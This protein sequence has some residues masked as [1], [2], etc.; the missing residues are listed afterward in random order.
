MAADLPALRLLERR[1]RV[2]AQLLLVARFIVL[3]LPTF[4]PALSTSWLLHTP[5]FQ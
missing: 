2:K 5:G 1:P 4:I 3:G